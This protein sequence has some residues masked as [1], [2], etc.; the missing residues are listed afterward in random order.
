[1]DQQPKIPTLKDSQKPQV[2]VRGLEAGVTLFDR[3]KQFK[4]KDLAFILAGLGTLF[5]APLAEHFMMSPEGGDATLGQGFGKGGAGN[6]GGI[7]GNGGSVAPYDSVNGQ[8]P[9]SAIG[10]GSDVITP[11]NVRDPSALVM[12]PGATQQPPTNSVAPATPPPT[13][14]VAR[15]DSDLKDALAASARGVGAGARAAKALLPVPKV[16]LG[17]SGLH[18]LGVASGGSSASSSLAPISSNGL[19]S[20]KAN[21]G[22]GGLNNVRAAPGYKGVARGQSAGGSG[23]EALKAAANNAGDVMNRGAASTALDQAAAQQIPTG[24]SG[25]SGAGAGG[26]GGGDKPDSGNAGKDS[27]STGESLEFLKQKA[28]QEA[29]IALWAKEQE[30][31]DNKLEMLKLRNS[32]AEAIAGKIGGA[33]GD[34]VTCPMTKGFK[35]C[36]GP[37]TDP[38]QYICKDGPGGQAIAIPGDQVGKCGPPDN[39]SYWFAGTTIGKCDSVAKDSTGGGGMGGSFATGCYSDGAKDAKDGGKTP[40]KGG[41]GSVGGAGNAQDM[42]K[43][44]S[45]TNLAQACSALDELS[46]TMGKLSNPDVTKEIASIKEK[47]ENAKAQAKLTVALRDAVNGPV[48]TDCGASS[49]G[50]TDPLIHQQNEILKSIT[51]DQPAEKP[52]GILPKLAKALAVGDPSKN[53]AQNTAEVNP[54]DIPDA[55][56]VDDAITKSDGDVQKI[57]NTKP[58]LAPVPS[59]VEIRKV[60]STVYRMPAPQQA[61]QVSETT[62]LFAQVNE[63]RAAVVKTA[64]SVIAN[65]KDLTAMTQRLD[66]AAGPGGTVA[67]MVPLGGKIVK[68]MRDQTFKDQA[69]N[70]GTVAP[71]KLGGAGGKASGIPDLTATAKK[72]VEAGSTAFAQY[73]AKIDPLKADPSAQKAVHDDAQTGFIPTNQKMSAGMTSLN[74]ARQAQ[75]NELNNLN[76]TAQRDSKRLVAAAPAAS[77]SAASPQS[78]ADE[79]PDPAEAAD[80]Q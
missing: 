78:A 5:M 80:G 76:A 19:T 23:M 38:G 50:V 16:A 36:W 41:P 75:A 32:M 11:L 65:N 62:N 3:L 46:A 68:D 10:G 33:I 26:A 40:P 79:S 7:F 77:P 56:L 45:V 8:A 2:K 54:K 12:G 13:A 44:P 14:P 28:M 37:A 72:D 74:K 4:K 51:A 35:K 43:L 6:G 60:Y 31:G 63:A 52:Y 25:P 27:K 18:G 17:G 55:K 29:Q 34:A 15:S 59:A 9:G 67:G 49:L 20:G 66:A 39:P 53:D 24:G 1:M 73:K 57:V 64:S 30:A 48:T 21:A 69:F 47:A 42:M 22:G 71:V 58:A 70:I 61:Q